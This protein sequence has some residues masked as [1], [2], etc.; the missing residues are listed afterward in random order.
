MIFFDIIPSVKNIF[1]NFSNTVKHIWQTLS[2]K[3]KH[4]IDRRPFISFL[5]V[6]AALFLAVVAGN[7]LRQPPKT[8]PTP[9][10]SPTPVHV[11]QLTSSPHMTVEAKIEKSGVIKLVAQTSGVV[12]KIRKHE[13]DHVRRGTPLFSLSTSYQGGNIPDLNRQLAARNEQFLQDTYDE[14]KSAIEGQ[15]QIASLTE[16]QAEQLRSI[17]RQSINE[18]NSLINLDNDIIASIDAQIQTLQNANPG[19]PTI[20]GLKEQKTIYLSSLNGA[21]AAVRNT[22]YQSDDTKEPAQ[23]A[24]TLRDLTLKQ[25]DVQE[26]MLDLNKDVSHLNLRISQVNE[27]LM[28][29]GSPCPGTIERMYVKVGQAVTPGTLLAAI[30]GDKNTATAVALVSDDVAQ[31]MSRVA[32]SQV[33][34]KDKTISLAPISISQEPTDGSLH[35]VIYQ[36]PDEDASSLSDGSFVSI[37]LPMGASYTTGLPFVPLDAI[38]QTQDSAYV[39][40]IGRDANGQQVVTAKNVTLGNVFGHDVEV[41]SGLSA[42]DQV[43]TDRSVVGGERVSVAQ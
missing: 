8:L 10:A 14:S 12:Q 7:A 31:H 37:S 21:K 15:K 11:F 28:F 2:D 6:L 24:S 33:T 36:L 3:L 19:D 1:T 5:G 39:Y 34:L 22:Q 40:V 27:S 4:F 42:T 9:Q 20:L 13:N 29:P 35:S 26:K 25:L 23:I 41:Q 17:S 32:L 30:R 16:T 38:Y 43:I 18:T